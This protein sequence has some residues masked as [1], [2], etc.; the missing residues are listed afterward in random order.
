MFPFRRV[1]AVLAFVSILLD[2]STTERGACPMASAV[3]EQADCC[4]DSDSPPVHDECDPATPSPDARDG[5]AALTGTTALAAVLELPLDAPGRLTRAAVVPRL[6]AG[7][8][9]DPTAP[10]TPPPR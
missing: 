9:G 4:L 5:H 8:D 3:A 2:A 6:Q 7:L 10:A 1:L